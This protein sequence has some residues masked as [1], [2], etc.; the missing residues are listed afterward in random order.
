MEEGLRIVRRSVIFLVALGVFAAATLPAQAAP[1]ARAKLS[2]SNVTPG[3]Q[4]ADKLGRADPHQQLT[5]GVNL[6]LRNQTQLEALIAQVSDRNASNYGHYLTPDQ[7]TATYGPTQVQVQEVTDVLSADGLSVGLVSSNRTIVA[8][9][10]N[11][12][13]TG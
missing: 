7:F 9:T 11:N 2:R 8:A 5:I 12:A 3:L 6:A 4:R 10:G 13:H 1:V